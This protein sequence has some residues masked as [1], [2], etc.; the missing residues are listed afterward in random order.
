MRASCESTTALDM[1]DGDDALEAEDQHDPGV[2]FRNIA[3]T[4]AGSVS[5]PARLGGTKTRMV[6]SA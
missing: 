4:Q 3:P 6:A 2:A 5:F 1:G